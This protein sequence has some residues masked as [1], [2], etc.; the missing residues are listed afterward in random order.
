MH[1]HIEKLQNETGT[2]ARHHRK[3]QD[4][5]GAAKEYFG[6]KGKV[7]NRFFY[8]LGILLAVAPTPTA[9]EFEIAEHNYWMP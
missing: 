5:L 2:T 3:Q 9:R 4:L 6:G 7:F 1:S 8:V